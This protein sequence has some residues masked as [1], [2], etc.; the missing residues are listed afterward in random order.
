MTQVLVQQVNRNSQGKKN[1]SFCETNLGIFD[2]LLAVKSQ[3]VHHEVFCLMGAGGLTLPQFRKTL[4]NFF[5]L[6]ENFPKFMALNLAKTR[7]H[8]PGHEEAKSWL[9]S[10]IHVEQNHAKWYM[11][12]AEG[13]GISREEILNVKPTPAMEAVVHHLWNV[14]TYKTVSVCFGAANV[15]IEWATGEWS[16]KV[17]QGVESYMERGL[18]P[19]DRRITSWLKAH[20]TYDDTHPYE[21]MD[22]VVKCAENDSD[23]E[24]AVQATRRSLEYYVMAL[25]DCLK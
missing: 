6:V 22:L 20:G 12:W 8:L 2:E 19:K 15:G 9:I 1:H 4:L 10:N 23:L 5:P 17:K 7:C 14:N 11:A 13:F 25:D 24:D 3:V 21:A 18:V 16:K